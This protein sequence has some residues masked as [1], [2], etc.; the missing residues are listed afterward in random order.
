MTDTQIAFLRLL[1]Q[2]IA[3]PHS[4]PHQAV[5][6]LGAVQAQDFLA[7]LWAI[8]LRCKAANE[9]TL[10]QEIQNRTIVR[11]WP[12]RGT[13]HWV[14][15]EDVWWMLEHLAP[16]AIAARAKRYRELELDSTTLAQSGKILEGLLLG[17]KCLT[18]SEI[19]D[20]FEANGISTASGRGMHLL[21]YHAHTQL[22]CFGP[23]ARKQPT[24]TLLEE[25][26]PR[27]P[28]MGREE[29]LSE[30]AGRYFSSHGPCTLQ[31]FAWW[32]GLNLG[33]VRHALEAIQGDLE[34]ILLNH[35][36]YYWKPGA[37]TSAPADN[38]LLPA[39]DEYLV[40]YAKRDNV[41]DSAFDKLYHDGGGI[42]KPVMVFGGRV[43]GTWKRSLGAKTVQ[44]KLEPFGP[45]RYNN[46]RFDRA[47]KQYA[48]F[49]GKAVGP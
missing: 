2:G 40:A 22:I 46:H 19:Y 21:G 49:L 20:C 26:V 16:K 29:A 7:S 30:L 6:R 28:V 33:E 5:Q 8:G 39:F 14:A 27:R 42:L 17:G 3:Q 43:I 35:R 38:Y 45:E 25:W 13:I 23:H 18:R 36:R 31:D 11:T 4:S 47:A 10:Q 12:M 37:K 44:I 9:A 15:A 32:A 34:S 41:L 1:N 24:F 48:A